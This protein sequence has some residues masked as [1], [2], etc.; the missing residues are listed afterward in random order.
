[1]YP[2]KNEND[3]GGQKQCCTHDDLASLQIWT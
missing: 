1:M 3:D 2:S